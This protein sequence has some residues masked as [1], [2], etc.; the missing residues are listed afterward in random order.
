MK[1]YT[2]LP[3]EKVAAK[4]LQLGPS[5]IPFRGLGRTRHRT[6]KISRRQTRAHQL[7]PNFQTAIRAV[8][9]VQPFFPQQV[10]ERTD[11][12]QSVV[13]AVFVCVAD[14]GYFD[15][16]VLY[17]YSAAVPVI[18]RLDDGILHQR[19]LGIYAEVR[20]SAEATFVRVTVLH[21]GPALVK[22]RGADNVIG[23]QNLS[24]EV[25]A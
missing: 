21:L 2:K 25:R 22:T 18:G 5:V 7:S 24:R 23:R 1:V 11:V 12:G 13:E 9:S 15:P 6:G 19:R 14:C 16:T 20:R 3:Q 8:P 4:R 10:S 17:V